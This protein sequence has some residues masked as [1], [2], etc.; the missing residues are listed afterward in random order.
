MNEKNHVY[1]LTY[2]DHLHPLYFSLPS[3]PS[4][5]PSF[6]NFTIFTLPKKSW[7]PCQAP[8]GSAVFRGSGGAALRD[9]KSRQQYQEG[10]ESGSQV[11]YAGDVSK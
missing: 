10:I 4:F 2:Y 8:V 11:S 3:L 9:G 1:L 5:L 6:L 7:R